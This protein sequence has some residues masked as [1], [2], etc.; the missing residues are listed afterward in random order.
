ML[1]EIRLTINSFLYITVTYGQLEVQ[2]NRNAQPQA[3]VG[4]GF[5]PITRSST[6]TGMLDFTMGF[7]LYLGK[8]HGNYIMGLTQSKQL[9]KNMYLFVKTTRLVAQELALRITVLR[10]RIMG[11]LNS[12]ATSMEL[13][14]LVWETIFESLFIKF[15][16]YPRH[17]AP[18]TQ[19]IS[20]FLGMLFP[21]LQL[22]EA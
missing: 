8:R 1:M 21:F 12:R 17:S 14:N 2:G 22:L 19:L 15:L 10:A 5:L 6:V 11:S 13:L 16:L 7:L 4:Y 3:Q 18:V 9:T 20:S